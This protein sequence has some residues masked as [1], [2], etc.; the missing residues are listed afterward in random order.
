MVSQQAK[1]LSSM[2]AATNLKYLNIRLW[3]G[4]IHK[5]FNKMKGS[6]IFTIKTW[7]YLKA[8]VSL[9]RKSN[10]RYHCSNCINIVEYLI[11]RYLNI[12]SSNKC[13]IAQYNIKQFFNIVYRANKISKSRKFIHHQFKKKK[14]NWAKFLTKL[15]SIWM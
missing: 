3:R 4:K 6:F 12:F 7:K 1:I 15:N 9:I 14:V 13:W 10:S 2:I 8:N 11:C 5:W